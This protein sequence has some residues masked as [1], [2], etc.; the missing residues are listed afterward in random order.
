MPDRYRKTIHPEANELVEFWHREKGDRPL[1]GKT[2]MDPTKLKRWIGDLSIIEL[3]EGPKRF[4]VRLHGGRT[5]DRVG[6]DMTRCY[7]ED[8]LDSGTLEFAVTP[9]RASEKSLLPTHSVFVPCLYPSVFTKLERL[10]LPFSAEKNV[11]EDPK[12][13]QF[14]VWVGPTGRSNIDDGSVYDKINSEPASAIDFSGIVELEI[15]AS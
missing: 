9:Y 1:P 11:P 7:F 10:V 4:F 5:Q 14:L 3:H 6:N 8:H 12:V 2:S 13:E 15:L